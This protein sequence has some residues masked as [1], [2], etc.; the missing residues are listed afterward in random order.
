MRDPYL[1]EMQ[2]IY[3]HQ[4][5]LSSEGNCV[6]Y[7]SIN[8]LNTLFLTSLSLH[9][10]HFGEQSNPRGL[11]PFTTLFSFFAYNMADR[12]YLV[13]FGPNA[14]CTFEVRLNPCLEAVPV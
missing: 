13:R 12:Q 2:S 14:N 10:F 11:Q 1:G 7:F 5:R 6:S 9:L 8:L 3:S 4:A